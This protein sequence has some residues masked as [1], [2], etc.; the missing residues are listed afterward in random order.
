MADQPGQ[1]HIA[2]LQMDI[3]VGEPEANFANL[4]LLLNKAVSSARKP[5]VIMFPEMWN[6]G[7][8]LEYI[9]QLADV[10]GERTKAA[11]SG[12]AREHGVVIIGAP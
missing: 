1:L 12:F 7:Y 2:L 3:R 9:Q 6:T 11:L 4:E 5:D 10:N 8:A